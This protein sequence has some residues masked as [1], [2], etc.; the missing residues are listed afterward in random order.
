MNIEKLLE[1]LSMSRPDRDF[2]NCILLEGKVYVNISKYY[3]GHNFRDAVWIIEGGKK[4][5]VPLSYA[6]P[7][8]DGFHNFHTRDTTAG[9][10]TIHENRMIFIGN[11]LYSEE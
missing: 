6:G 11:E 8:G 1:Q 2:D 3:D 9:P 4:R 7:E 5:Y 10:I